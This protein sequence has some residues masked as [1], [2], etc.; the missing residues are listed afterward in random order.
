[1]LRVMDRI[2]LTPDHITLLSLLMG[3]AFCPFYLWLDGDWTIHVARFF[4][5]GH[6]IVDGID[7]PLARY[8][9][10]AGP[11]GSFTDTVADQIGLGATTLAFMYAEW[12]GRPGVSLFGGGIFL[13][14]YTVVVAF[15]MVRNAMGIPYRFLL[16]P[17]YYL[18]MLLFVETYFWHSPVAENLTE[19]FVWASNA[20]FAVLTLTGF[21]AIRRGL[22]P[23]TA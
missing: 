14:L 22:G 12:I 11:Q 9:K 7:G 18:W 10:T 1:M 19:G 6:F 23:S 4:M 17:R 15:A 3:F 8:Q 2:G 21:L 13:F 20:M 5:I 16:R